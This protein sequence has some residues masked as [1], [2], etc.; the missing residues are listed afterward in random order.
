MTDS[1]TEHLERPRRESLGQSCSGNKSLRA[2]RNPGNFG[3]LTERLGNFHESARSLADCWHTSDITRQTDLSMIEAANHMYH[4][5]LEKASDDPERVTP[6]PC[7]GLHAEATRDKRRCPR[8]RHRMRN[9]ALAPRHRAKDLV[10]LQKRWSRNLVLAPRQQAKCFVLV[11]R[12][13]VLRVDR[14]SK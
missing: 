2:T 5:L 8:P 4:K 11:P 12:Q 3:E 13:S 6:H 14:W 10:F 7:E 1:V 9:L